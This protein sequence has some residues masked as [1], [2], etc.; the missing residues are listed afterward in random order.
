MNQIGALSTISSLLFLLGK[1]FIVASSGIAG[2]LWLDNAPAFREGTRSLRCFL[3]RVRWYARVDWLRAVWQAAH[4]RYSP[5]WS[6]WLF[7]CC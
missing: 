1:I 3:E 7:W 2:F 6:P 4:M 5:S